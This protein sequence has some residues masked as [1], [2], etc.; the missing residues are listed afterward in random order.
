MIAI[1]PKPNEA[2]YTVLKAWLYAVGTAAAIA[3]SIESVTPGA[4]ATVPAVT[5]ARTAGTSE[6]GRPAAI[7][8]PPTTAGMVV[9]RRL[10]RIVEYTA[11]AIEPP[12]L[13]ARCND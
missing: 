7:A 1:P 5:A 8:A 9:E 13:L 11:T 3:A 6:A 12:E 2:R 10:V 4:F